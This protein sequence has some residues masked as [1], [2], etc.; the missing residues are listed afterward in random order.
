MSTGASYT[1]PDPSP[2]YGMG[3]ANADGAKKLLDAA[4]SAR[5]A[6]GAGVKTMPQAR[7]G[8]T[9]NT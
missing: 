9:G 7:T 6:A 1:V 3:N 5:D 4:E 2:G 8:G